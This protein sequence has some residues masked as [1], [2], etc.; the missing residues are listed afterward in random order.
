MTPSLQIGLIG[1]LPPPSG[2]MANQTQQLAKLLQRDGLRVEV[3]QTN[4][5][6]RP[7]WVGSVPMLRAVFRLVLYIIQLWQVAGR[8]DL[9][10]IMAN[11]GWSWH[12]FAAPAVW[13]AK[14]RSVPTVINYRGG[15][16]EQFFK[17]SYKWVKPTMSASTKI[18]VPSRFL[19]EVFSRYEC[20]T[21]IVAN[22][23]DLQRFSQGEQS[24][25]R[26]SAPHLLVARN[27]EPIYDNE[28][29]IRAFK[30]VLKDFPDARLTIAG[31]G[32]EKQNLMLLAKEL[33]IEK[34]VMFPGRIDTRDM[35]AL[36]RSAQL[37]LNP[38]TVD[39]MP[40]SV[41]ESLA[42]GVPVVTTNVGGIPFIVEHERTAL[43]VPARDYQAMAAA[44]VR[45]LKQNE[46]R[47]QLVRGGLKYVEQYSWPVVRKLW[48][49]VY[50][51]VVG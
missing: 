10:H 22:I 7:R 33:S 13:I 21:D 31:T 24:T 12:L 30:E 38:S 51:Q 35:P 47:E 17:K 11:S 50:Q 6:Y 3:V 19:R 8:A 16:A 15:E 46:L 14:L 45:L 32:P 5:P 18:I 39:N 48:I 36:Y 34:K 4:R 42:S 43:L 1:P 27:L 2:G 28:T 40:N 23:I 26:Y 9:F 25:S 37:M 41:L 20:P 44:V 29:A 49:N